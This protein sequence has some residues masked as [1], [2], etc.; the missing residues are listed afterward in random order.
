MSVMPE[1]AGADRPPE[2][3]NLPHRGH[4]AVPRIAS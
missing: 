2:R 1:V 4:S 3:L